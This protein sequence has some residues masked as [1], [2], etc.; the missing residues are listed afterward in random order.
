MLILTCF[1]VDINTLEAETQRGASC[2]ADLIKFWAEIYSKNDHK[3]L[4]K[5]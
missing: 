1:C 2:H 5:V 4:D 3:S